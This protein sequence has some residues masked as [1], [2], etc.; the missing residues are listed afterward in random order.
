MRCLEICCG[1]IES[2]EAAIKGGA[3][4]IELCSALEVGGLT[5]SMGLV[6]AA[7]D[8]GRRAG[9]PVNVLIRPRGG[10]FVYSQREM[11]IMLNDVQEC[12]VEGV[13]GVV[14][15]VLT[16][17]G[18]VDIQA[19]RR[20]IWEAGAAEVTFHRAFDL[21]RDPEV[22]LEQII[23]LGCS[24]LLTSGCE[25]TANAGIPMLKRLVSRANGRIAI[26]AGSG[27]NAQNAARIA[28]Y[29]Q[30]P[31]LHASARS[32]RASAMKYRR[33]GVSMSAPGADEYSR[34]VTNAELVSEIKSRIQDEKDTA[35]DMPLRPALC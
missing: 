26:M 16:L 7:L 29:T 21:C 14:V 11:A 2:V 34:L 17:N 35:A 3:D 20:L 15:G 22:A 18:D 1:D 25:P 10:D 9:V 12:V 19:M 8:M 24:R 28:S 4:R 23:D 6:K 31:E 30:V 33:P 5:P 32:P 13:N 27:V